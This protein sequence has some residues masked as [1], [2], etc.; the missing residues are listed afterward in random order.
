MHT[1]IVLEWNQFLS[2]FNDVK[3]I[4]HPL[5]T[6]SASTLE[7]DESVRKTIF[8]EQKQK[9]HDSSISNNFDRFH[10]TNFSLFYIAFKIQSSDKDDNKGITILRLLN[11]VFLSFVLTCMK[12]T[13]K[14]GFCT[15]KICFD[16]RKRLRR[17]KELMNST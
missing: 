1:Y 10:L 16:K 2:L 15:L 3:T 5:S 11:L 12:F 6:L 9:S 14:V 4:I 8:Y 17:I 13:R 7:K